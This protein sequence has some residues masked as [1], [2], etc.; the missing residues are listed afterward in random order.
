MR[1]GTRYRFDNGTVSW[2]RD[3][4]GNTITF[5]YDSFKRAT[6]IKDS[7]KREVSIIY[8]TT[9][10]LYDEIVYKGFGGALRSLRV[11]Y[12]SL[13]DPGSLRAGYSAQTE[14]E[15]LEEGSQ[16]CT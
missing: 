3:R 10:V 12:A 13:S 4:N 1:D 16:G 8:A 9:T 15:S 14:S 7:L 2:L 11:N 5:T 6:T